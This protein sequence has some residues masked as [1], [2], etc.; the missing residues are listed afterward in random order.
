MNYTLAFGMNLIQM[1]SIRPKIL[2]MKFSCVVNK[3]NYGH[4]RNING[5]S[6]NKY[7]YK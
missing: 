1:P 6:H 2:H 3:G 7:T 5:A 4:S